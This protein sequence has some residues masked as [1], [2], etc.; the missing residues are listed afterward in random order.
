MKVERFKDRAAL[1]GALIAQLQQAIESGGGL[2]LSGGSTPRNAYVQLSKLALRAPSSLALLF[3]DDRYVPRDSPSSNYRMASPLIESLRLPQ[4]QV[5]RVRTELPLEQAA[6]DYERQLSELIAAQSTIRLGLLG[7]GADGHTASLFA[8]ADLEHSRN[9]L[10]ISVQRP[11][12]MQAVSVTSA[13]LA[14]VD[15]LLFVVIG[16]DKQAALDA[17]LAGDPSLIA[18]RAVKECPAVEVW[19]A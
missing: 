12:G 5:L 2:M 4:A 17:L 8:P 16:Q 19:T 11:D 3:S 9:R 18:W 6:A 13:L 10:A 14:R 1:D 7:L 15:R